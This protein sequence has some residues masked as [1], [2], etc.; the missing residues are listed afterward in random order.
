[1]A[2]GNKVV[3]QYLD[4]VHQTSGHFFH[5]GARSECLV[6]IT[7]AV[8]VCKLDVCTLTDSI[9][10]LSMVPSLN[11]LLNSAWQNMSRD[12]RATREATSPELW[13]T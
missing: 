3:V 13:M 7:V 6:A 8:Y 1:M 4:V 2:S 9:V 10:V 12:S 11:M 5:S